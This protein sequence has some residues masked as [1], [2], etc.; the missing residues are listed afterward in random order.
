MIKTKK[1]INFLTNK[2]IT[3]PEELSCQNISLKLKTNGELEEQNFNKLEQAYLDITI[4]KNLI[5]FINK[6]HQVLIDDYDLDIEVYLKTKCEYELKIYK[7]DFFRLIYI[8]MTEEEEDRF[9]RYLKLE[10]KDRLLAVKKFNSEVPLAVKIESGL[11]LI[12][13]YEQKV[14][15]YLKADLDK[16]NFD[17]E[18]VLLKGILKENTKQNKLKYR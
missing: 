11:F 3:D 15:N 10:V 4:C 7:D 5:T 1:I 8:K 9:S 6:Y 14:T 17:C 13:L 18:L 16:A 2:G 12:N